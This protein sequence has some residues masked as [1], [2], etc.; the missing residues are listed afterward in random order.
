MSQTAIPMT[1]DAN[2]AAI[3]NDSSWFPYDLD[4]NEGTFEFVQVTAE[5]LAAE[6]T[7]SR[8]SWNP[9]GQRHRLSIAATLA[10]WPDLPAAPANFLWSTG[11]CSEVMVSRALEKKGASVAIREPDTL[12]RLADMKRAKMLSDP[13]YQ[14]LSRALLG[15]LTRPLAANAGTLIA[16]SPSSALL[17]PEV[18][19][20]TIGKSLFLYSDLRCFLIQV[21][22]G[23]ELARG[24]IRRMFSV[25]AGDGHVQATWPAT[26]L[27]QMTDLQIAALVWH[28]QMVQFRRAMALLGPRAASLDIDALL[29]S[30]RT[31]LSA[32]DDFFGLGLGH[33]FLDETAEGPIFRKKDDDGKVIS[34]AWEAVE[35]ER[36]VDSDLAAH[37]NFLIERTYEICKSPLGVP[38]PNALIPTD[39]TYHR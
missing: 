19:E 38:L 24:F 3:L 30:P 23:G 39:K 31:T 35:A 2:A 18:A 4:L 9:P 34:D 20:L 32:L 21:A 13:R 15:L 33:P 12:T 37:L 10:G 27:F 26:N 29:Q 7:A 25:I 22:R 16:G 28:M 36:R 11:F 8:A 14:R 17:A 6:M 1:D 5:A